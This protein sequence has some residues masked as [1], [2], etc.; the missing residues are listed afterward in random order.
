MPRKLSYENVKKIYEDK[1]C[2]LLT[3]KDTF[4]SLTGNVNDQRFEFISKCGHHNNIKLI[5]F[6]KKN[7]EQLCTDCLEKGLLQDLDLWYKDK[8][9]QEYQSMKCSLLSFLR[10]S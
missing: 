1:G 5:T 4:D 6:K 10:R 9:S 7:A 3:S 2:T 8:N